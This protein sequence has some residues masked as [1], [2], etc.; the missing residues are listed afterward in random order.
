[1]PSLPL[2]IEVGLGLRLQLCVGILAKRLHSNMDTIGWRAVI[3]F[4]FCSGDFV[5]HPIIDHS[6][7]QSKSQANT[8]IAEESAGRRRGC[9][10]PNQLQFLEDT[11]YLT[12]QS[13]DFDHLI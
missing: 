10:S 3:C 8:E 9:L 5:D 6:R 1:M 11:G 12:S 7:M 4:Y 2:G 13:I